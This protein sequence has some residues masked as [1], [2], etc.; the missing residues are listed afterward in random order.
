V[1][2]TDMQPHHLPGVLAIERRS[3]P[4]P[5]S[6]R[7][8]AAE[9]NQNAYAQYIVALRG[10]MV[11]G[12]AGM[13]LIM[14]EAH[15]TNIAVHPQ[16]RRRGLGHRLLSELEARAR[17]HGCRRM[18]LEV[19]PSNLGAQRLYQRH[20]FVV[21]GVRPGYYADTREDALIMWK[22]GLDT[23]HPQA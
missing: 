10:A 21:C 20:G 8:F 2:I 3:Y 4:T 19:R 22:E 5:W 15:I 6:E 23:P 13:W 12:Y 17:A 1:V 7:A 9:L 14:D 11:L 16:E 18:T